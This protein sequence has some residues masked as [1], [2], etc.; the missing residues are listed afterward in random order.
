MNPVFSSIAAVGAQST[1]KSTAKTEDGALIEPAILKSSAVI[2]LNSEQ[3][4]D[5]RLHALTLDLCNAINDADAGGDVSSISAR[6]QPAS[7]QEGSKGGDL[8]TIGTLLLTLLGSGGVVVTLIDVLKT[9]VM[10]DRHLKIKITANDGASIEL[11][12][13]NLAENELHGTTEVVQKVL[14]SS[15]GRE[16]VRS[17]NR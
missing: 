3:L 16:A 10:R 5:V 4:D 14:E 13:S 17:S 6:S 2:T 1:G 12:A 9:Y 11:D 15:H 8:V 7:S